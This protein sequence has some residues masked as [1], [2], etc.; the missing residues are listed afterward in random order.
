M[1]KDTLLVH[2]GR[3][4]SGPVNPPVARASTILFDDLATFEA[5]RA[6]RFSGLRYGIHGTDTLF[7]LEEAVTKLEGCHRAIIVPSGLAAITCSIIAATKPG[8]NILV[9][10]TVYGPTRAFCNGLLKRMGVR[11]I[12]YDPCI[13]SAIAELIDENTCA[14][15]CET[16]G[17]LTF[18]VQDIP[19]IA[20]AA[21]ER[22][23]PV[24]VD[25]TWATPLFFDA[26]A[27][28]ADISIQA[29]TKYLCGH[30]DV[31]MGTVATTEKWWRPI[32]DTVAD[33]GF[34]T[35]PDDCYLALRGMRTLAPRLRQQHTSGLEVATW[36][37][38]QEG[39]L[40]VIHPGLQDDPGHGLW[41]RDFTGASG[42]FGIELAT[43]SAHGLAAFIDTLS[44]FGLGSSWGG[45]E[46]L[47][48]PARFE[49]LQRP[50]HL[51]GTLVRLHVGLEDPSDLIADLA[52]ALRALE[53]ASASEQKP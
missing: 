23:I 46:S 9:A 38:K 44:L 27:H 43:Q 32:R 24:I 31:M 1:K 8:G 39:I 52:C 29:A 49:R 35:S 53:T 21:H 33:L 20:T 41:Q 51:R 11:T 37:R 36:L 3:R 30:S 26:L 28:G 50:F 19:A 4:S 45:Y 6:D 34:S 42:L 18:E 22:E 7:A 25:N 2:G 16:P 47:V 13:N 12:Y 40:R 48:I 10:D 5:S 15:Y 17:S 14:I